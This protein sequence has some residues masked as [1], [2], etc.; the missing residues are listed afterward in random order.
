MSSTLETYCRGVLV[1]I[2]N[3]TRLVNP[4]KHVDVNILVY[5]WKTWGFRPC[6][7]NLR[8]ASFRLRFFVFFP[9]FR[10]ILPLV[11]Y[12]HAISVPD[13]FRIIFLS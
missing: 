10:S 6:I 7:S 12:V 5:P 8:H 1:V 9:F 3:P 11:A 4:A 13:L 2:D